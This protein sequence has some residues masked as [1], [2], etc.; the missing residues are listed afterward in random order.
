MIFCDCFFHCNLVFMQPFWRNLVSENAESSKVGLPIPH[1]QIKIKQTNEQFNWSV[2]YNDF[3]F[4]WNIPKSNDFQFEL[5][6]FFCVS[7]FVPPCYWYLHFDIRLVRYTYVCSTP[8]LSNPQPVRQFCM[9]GKV[10]CNWIY[11]LNQWNFKSRLLLWP[12]QL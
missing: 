7:H 6:I 3:F 12:F 1:W 10:K 4:L 9:A 2:I 11:L 8:G 5:Q